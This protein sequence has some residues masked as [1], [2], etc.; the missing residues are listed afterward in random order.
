MAPHVTP[1]RLSLLLIPL[2]LLAGGAVRAESA[3]ELFA[4]SCASCHGADGK[5]HTPMGRK[6]HARDL[7]ESTLADADIERQ[8]REGSKD[9]RRATKMP[10]FADKLT[11]EQ[12][13]ALVEYVK[14]FRPKHT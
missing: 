11:P 1:S 4:E 3:A 7:S 12:I 5:A 10:A 2:S 8:I 9:Q 13:K 14:S 6:A